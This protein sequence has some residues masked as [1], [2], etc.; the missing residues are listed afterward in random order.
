MEYLMTYGWAILVISV[1]LVSLYALGLFNPASFTHTSCIFPADFS[2]LNSE[3]FSNG[4][5]MINV[6]QSTASPINITAIGCN[7][8]DSTADMLD[9]SANQIYLQIGSNVSITANGATA[10][11]CWDNSTVFTGK[12]GSIFKGYVI[13]NYTNIETGFPHTVSAILIQKVT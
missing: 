8:N 4:T 3:L 9:F 13:M 12:P 7:A 6:E 1:A 10:L 11:Q 5:F 2:C